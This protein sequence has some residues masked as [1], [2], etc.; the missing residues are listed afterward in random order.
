MAACRSIREPRLLSR[1]GPRTQLSMGPAEGGRKRKQDNLGPFAAYAQDPV[2]MFFAEVADVSTSGFED[3]QDQSS[4]SIATGSP[5]AVCPI[6]K[7]RT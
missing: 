7:T 4:P 2:A 1:I 3:P 5:Q 6:L